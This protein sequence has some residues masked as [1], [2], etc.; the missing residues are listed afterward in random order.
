[1]TTPYGPR[2]EPGFRCGR[3]S[4][5]PSPSGDAGPAALPTP[6]TVRHMTNPVVPVVPAGA[7]TRATPAVPAVPERPARRAQLPTATVNDCW[8]SPVDISP[9]TTLAVIASE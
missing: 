6:T 4:G 7:A 5:S 3:F 9:G 1:M 8:L 2:G